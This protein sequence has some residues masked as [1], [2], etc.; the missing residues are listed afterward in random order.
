[1]SDP[2]RR[3]GA[4]G[5]RFNDCSERV[6]IVWFCVR[7]AERAKTFNAAAARAA[8]MVGTWH[9]TDGTHYPWAPA[10]AVPCHRTFLLPSNLAR[11]VSSVTQPCSIRGQLHWR[12]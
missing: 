3:L 1:M 7:G 2:E 5:R 10:D 9:R 6:Q 11:R 4:L 8:S 12:T